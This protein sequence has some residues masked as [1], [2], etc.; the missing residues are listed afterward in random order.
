MCTYT[1]KYVWLCVCVC[2]CVFLCIHAI[3]QIS[4]HVGIYFM[5]MYLYVN[6]IIFILHYLF[7]FILPTGR[8]P[9]I[10]RDVDYENK[11]L[12][13]CVYICDFFSFDNTVHLKIKQYKTIVIHRLYGYLF[14]CH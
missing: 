2:V 13:V 8:T 4:L 7:F 11:C 9:A 14:E 1:D 12:R 10:V 3:P 5:V 6:I